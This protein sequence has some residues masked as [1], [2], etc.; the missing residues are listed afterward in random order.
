MHMHTWYVLH[1]NGI[2]LGCRC[3]DDMDFA[4]SAYVSGAVIM[5]Y[6]MNSSTHTHLLHLFHLTQRQSLKPS[7]RGRSFLPRL[8]NLGP[9]QIQHS[10]NTP[11]R[12]RIVVLRRNYCCWTSWWHPWEPDSDKKT[13]AFLVMRTYAICCYI[14]TAWSSTSV[15][16]SEPLLA[17][18]CFLSSSK[19][20]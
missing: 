17:P 4:I 20:W 3:F 1:W 18:T 10:C 6:S 7:A 16:Q 11:G 12:E 14:P 2:E 13:A 9:K 15:F 5:K 19:A 8:S